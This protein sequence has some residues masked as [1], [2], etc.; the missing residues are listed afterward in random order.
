[1]KGAG[2]RLLQN[3]LSPSPQSSPCV[4]VLQIH[5]HLFRPPLFVDLYC[6]PDNGPGTGDAEW[7]KEATALQA[8]GVERKGWLVGRQTAPDSVIGVMMEDGPR[9]EAALEKALQP[10]EMRADGRGRDQG[11]SQVAQT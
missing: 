2:L 10:G 5:C 7:I 9:T 8:L 4:T 11:T 3:S 1:M 6:V